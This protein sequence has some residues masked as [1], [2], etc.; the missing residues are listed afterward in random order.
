MKAWDA[1]SYRDSMQEPIRR[2]IAN[3]IEWQLAALEQ[4]PG[5]TDD[6]PNA[7]L[8]LSLLEKAVA[9]GAFLDMHLFL[10]FVQKLLNTMA[11]EGPGADFRRRHEFIAA[12]N[13]AIQILTEQ[14]MPTTDLLLAQAR[15][16]ANVENN[17]TGRRLAIQAAIKA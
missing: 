7:D 10:K 12:T 2:S 14:G 11:L 1:A 3:A 15:Y 5:R 4:A 13:A 6:P 9:W 17:G 8:M 16:Y